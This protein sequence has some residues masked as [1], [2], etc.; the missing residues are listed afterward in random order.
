MDEVA[1]A[2]SVAEIGDK[3][4]IVE[5]A[6]EVVRDSGGRFLQ[7]VNTTQWVV[8]GDKKAFTKT[9]K[10]FIR[11]IANNNKMSSLETKTESVETTSL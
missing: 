5:K 1:A 11:A 7:K 2:E 3:I 9:R 10:A 8:V 6:I 4:N